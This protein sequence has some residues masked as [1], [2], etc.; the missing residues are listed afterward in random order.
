VG[1]A[2]STRSLAREERRERRRRL[3][4]E[5]LLER[6][7]ELDPRVRRVLADTDRPGVT[8]GFGGQAP[9]RHGPGPPGAVKRP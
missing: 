9:T 1:G 4:Q 5:G 7:G 6:A 8:A 2:R 3:E